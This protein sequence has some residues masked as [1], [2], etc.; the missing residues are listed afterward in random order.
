MSQIDKNLIFESLIQEA[1]EEEEITSEDCFPQHVI[2]G[3]G[4]GWFLDPQQMEMVRALR[5]TEIIPVATDSDYEDRVL[6]ALSSRILLI[7][8]SEILEV[9]WN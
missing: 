4:W 6:V 5:G 9:G 8:A 2:S 1:I 3:S 7:P